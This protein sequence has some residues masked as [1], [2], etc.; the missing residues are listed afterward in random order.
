MMSI[1]NPILG[2]NLYANDE[3][4]RA[5][6]RLQL[7]AETLEFTHPETGERCKFEAKCDF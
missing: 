2:D 5:A 6:D 4:F 7:H 3:A 1:G